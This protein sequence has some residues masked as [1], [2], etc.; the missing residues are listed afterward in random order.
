MPKTAVTQAEIGKVMDDLAK[1]IDLDVLTVLRKVAFDLLTK[2]VEKTPVDTG[3]AR[4]SWKVGIGRSANA[5]AT[6]GPVTSRGA[7][8]AK[9]EEK[10]NSLRLPKKIY[11]T[12]NLPYMEALENNHS[13]QAPKGMIEISLAETKNELNSL[14]TD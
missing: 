9:G 10:I 2:I 6:E 12:S 7:T 13:G 5:N 14:L 3:R 11:I 8:L 1:Q 4:S